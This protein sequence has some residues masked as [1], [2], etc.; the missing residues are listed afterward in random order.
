VV[1]LFALLAAVMPFGG[2]VLSSLPSGADVWVDGTYIGR[3]PV[4][5]DGLKAG[6]HP[7]TITKAG[8]RVYEADELVA[9]GAVTPSTIQLTAL[10]PPHEPGAIAFIGLDSSAKISI[11]GQPALPFTERYSVNT[12]THH[13]VVREPNIKYERD[14]NV[15]P[16]QTT[17]VLLPSPAAAVHSAVVAALTDY[18]PASAAKVS[19]DRLVVR[20]AGHVAVGHLGDAK[21][22][23]DG[24][25][26]VYDAPAGM[27]SGRLYLPLDLLVKMTDKK[28]K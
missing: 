13:V 15:F 16:D 27:V 4:L 23:V 25:N 24:R 3:T 5:I 18:M 19:G 9:A 21:F 2:L 8:W 14:I 22:V 20:F 10:N 26:V 12:G 1:L 17:H 11:D 6:K 28:S 7:V